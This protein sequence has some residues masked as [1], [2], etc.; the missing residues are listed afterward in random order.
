MLGLKIF[1]WAYLIYLLLSSIVNYEKE[2]KGAIII[3]AID[4]ISI[5]IMVLIIARMYA[6]S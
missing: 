6:P 3:K 2:N 5:F 4:T 1:C